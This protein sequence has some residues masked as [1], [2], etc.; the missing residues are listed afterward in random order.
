MASSALYL[1]DRAAEKGLTFFS[2]L[3]RD[4]HPRDFA[5]RLWDGSRLDADPGWTSRCTLV[6]N[7][8]GALR[9]MFL[10]ANQ[11]ALGEAYIYGDLDIEGDVEALFPLAPFL[12]NTKMSR[13][14]QLRLGAMLLGMPAGRPR[15]MGRSPVRLEG[16]PHS[17]ERDRQAVA[18]HYNVSNDFFRLFLD[19]RMVY[20]CAYFESP[21]LSLAEAQEHKLDYICRKLRL[22]PGERLLD[23]GCGWGAFMIHAAT[24]YGVRILGITLSEP[25]AELA[26]ERIRGAGLEDRCRVEV[27]DYRDLNQPENFDKVV[28]IGMVE[29]VGENMLPEYFAQAFKLLRPGG[30]FLNHGI[31]RAPWSKVPERPTFVDRYVFPDGDMVPI[32]I[33]LRHAAACGFEVR[34]VENLREHYTLTLRQWVQNLESHAQ[35]AR[36]LTDDS[37]YRTWRLYMAGSAYFFDTGRLNIYQSLLSKND[38]ISGLPLIRGDWYSAK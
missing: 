12:L 24:H 6:I 9:R 23:I 18:Y 29:H 10:P 36:Q 27:C 13:A 22:Q 20:S 25:Q 31:A 37:T 7:H 21:G 11:A 38:G 17:K 30:V 32:E 33:V 34:D 26:K 5:V 28:S 2:E 14:R 1:H 35:Q 4:F 8:P 16:S 3:L 19:E 15:R